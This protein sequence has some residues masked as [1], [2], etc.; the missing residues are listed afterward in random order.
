VQN[1]PNI[2]QGKSDVRGVEGS[3]GTRSLEARTKNEDT[4]EANLLILSGRGG[5]ESP[6]KQTNHRKIFRVR[7][8]KAAGKTTHCS[9]L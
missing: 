4:G 8:K 1:P 9:L 6:G 5:M 2:K 3:C 7:K